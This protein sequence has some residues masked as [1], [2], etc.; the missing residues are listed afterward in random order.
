MNF[1]ADEDA[2]LFI[3]IENDSLSLTIDS[4]YFENLL[5]EEK[6]HACTINNSEFSN[7]MIKGSA[8][9]F[10]L[11]SSELTNTPVRLSREKSEDTCIARVEDCIILYDEAYRI[12][13]TLNPPSAQDHLAETLIGVE[14]Y[15]HYLIL[16][17]SI[18]HDE[19]DGIT[20]YYA[21]S[22]IVNKVKDCY[23]HFSGDVSTD[24]SYGL[25]IYKSYVDV[26]K[27]YIDEHTTGVACLDNS[28][29]K[30]NS[31]VKDPD[32]DDTQHIIN[33]EDNQ[34]YILAGSF[35]YEF[36]YNYIYGSDTTEMY[37]Y[38]NTIYSCES[39]CY[40]VEN[41]Y[42]G[43]N[44]FIP[45]SNLYPIGEYN[46]L[47]LWSGYK[48]TPVDALIY[49]AGEQA[50]EDGNYPL[51]ES[52][53]KEIIEDFPNSKYVDASVKIMLALKR[54]YDQDYAEL[55]DYLYSIPSLWEDTTTAN[56]TDHVI[57]WCNI[58]KEDYVAAIIWFEDQIENPNSYADSIC[59]IIDLGYTYTLMDTTSNKSSGFIGNYPQYRHT[60][61]AAYEKNREYLV[62][63]LFR[64]NSHSHQKEHDPLQTASFFLHQNYPNPVSETTT[65]KYTISQQSDVK[66]NVYNIL[67]SIV[68]TLVNEMQR[69]GEKQVTFNIQNLS[70]G[71]YYYS[72]VVD[73]EII[74]V[75]KMLVLR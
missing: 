54:I 21:G 49:R 67:G 31:V 22:G 56:V 30:I 35:P 36:E 34:V 43:D 65:I 32:E 46:Y 12:N 62:D 25:I 23:L 66:L 5:F 61:R 14:Q 41:N 58:E 51:A 8:D 57:N 55:Q 52:K 64:K 19:L 33:N 44:G 75:R 74:G 47:P 6:T 59:A 29:S 27:N 7:S 71:L 37:V 13:D 17:D 70:N 10:L 72:L 53:F 42:W 73:N 39:P 45:D 18:V 40:D 4:A 20:L 68:T 15:H 48:N 28:N 38:L 63:L 2:S 3:Y 60:S 26:Q 11:S 69:E 9:Y 50:M 24:T 16:N 1:I